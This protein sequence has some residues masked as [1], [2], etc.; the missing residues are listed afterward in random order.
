MNTHR[1]TAML[2]AVLF[3]RDHKLHANPKLLIAFCDQ[4][5]A[6]CE[7]MSYEIAQECGIHA[8]RECAMPCWSPG[9]DLIEPEDLR[10]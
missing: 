4:W 5:L 10:D 3:L 9:M 2:Y 8:A 7:S 6:S 1:S